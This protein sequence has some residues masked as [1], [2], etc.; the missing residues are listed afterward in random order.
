MKLKSIIIF[1]ILILSL[2]TARLDAQSLTWLGTLG[3]ESSTAYAVSDDG[4]VIVGGTEN[5][6]GS[7][8]GFIWTP[9]SGIQSLTNLQNTNS[10]ARYVTPN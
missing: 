7:S 5:L 1:R 6:E 2:I 9:N 3:G 4:N 10:W 8:R